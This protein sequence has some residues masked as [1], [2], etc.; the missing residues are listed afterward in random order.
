[1]YLCSSLFLFLVWNCANH[2]NVSTK[3]DLAAFCI[4]IENPWHH[5]HTEGLSASSSRVTKPA[6]QD[7]RDY[8]AKSTTRING[9]DPTA[10]YFTT[11]TASD[12]FVAMTTQSYMFHTSEGPTLQPSLSALT[13]QAEGV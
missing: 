6:S 8:V 9:S 3:H 4:I 2:A 7:S 13:T 11:L 10:W 12:I 5:T 1:M